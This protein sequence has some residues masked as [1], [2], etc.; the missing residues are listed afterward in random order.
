MFQKNR[1]EQKNRSKADSEQKG[2]DC[3]FV[4]ANSQKSGA[5]SDQYVAKK[6]SKTN[7]NT[8]VAAAD[9]CVPVYKDLVRQQ[10]FVGKSGVAGQIWARSGLGMRQQFF[11]REEEVGVRQRLGVRQQFRREDEKMMKLGF[12]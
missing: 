5:K 3:R 4:W 7:Q 1:S 10:I 2:C 8:R 11:F 12:E 9:L 6:R